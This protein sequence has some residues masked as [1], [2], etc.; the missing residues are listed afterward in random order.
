MVRDFALLPGDARPGVRLRAAVPPFFG[1]PPETRFALGL[2]AEFAE[3]V[4]F[5][6]W[7]ATAVIR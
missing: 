7:G 4:F 5:R 6:A 3:V 1:P 2:V